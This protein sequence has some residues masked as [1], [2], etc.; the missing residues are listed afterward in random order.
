MKAQKS[1]ITHAGLELSSVDQLEK[2][3]KLLQR[4]RKSRNARLKELIT[5]D[6]DIHGDSYMKRRGTTCP[7]CLTLVSG[8][9]DVIEAHVNACIANAS[10]LQLEAEERERRVSELE[11]VRQAEASVDP[12]VEIE[13]DGAVRLHLANA[14]GLRSS[15]V[16]V[17]DSTQIDVEDEVDVDGDDEFGMAQFTEQDV[18]NP[19]TSGQLDDVDEDDEEGGEDGNKTLRDLVAEGKVVTRRTLTPDLNGVRAEVEEVI[20]VGDADR[21]N[22]AITAARRKGDK[23]RLI[24]AL[25]EKVKQLVSQ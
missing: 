1:M 12:W 10:R 2:T 13:V 21:M 11:L 24:A 15:G 16:H 7:I 19:V 4:R 14:R 17:R 23:N 25:E 8:D 3:L 20:G 6:D 18:I 22:E 9:E 5:Q